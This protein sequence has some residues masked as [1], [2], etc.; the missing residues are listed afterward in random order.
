[1]KK[2]TALL[3]C[4]SIT[5]AAR[6]D[7][8]PTVPAVNNSIFTVD[9]SHP[10]GTVSPILYGLMTEEINHSYDGGLYAELVRNRSFLDDPVMPVSWSVVN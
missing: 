9:A 1:M 10:A 8:A 7:T 3:I 5:V 4:A 6:A 2:L